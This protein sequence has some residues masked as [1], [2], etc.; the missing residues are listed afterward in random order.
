LAERDSQVEIEKLIL[1][2][3]DLDGSL[4]NALTECELRNPQFGVDW[5]SNLAS[6]A[7]A[8]HEQ[9]V[10]FVARRAPD[11]F[12]ALPMKLDLHNGHAHALGN[13]YTS[14][15][16]PVINS[17]KPESLLLNLF[18]H[19]ANNPKITRLT[20]S[21]MARDTPY[22]DQIRKSI[23]Q[24]GWKGIHSYFCFGNWIHEL[25]GASYQSY[26]ATRP[27]QL[28][29][30]ITRRT[31]QFLAGNR[32]KLELVQGGPLLEESIGQFVAVYNE[33]WKQEEP[34][35]DFIPNLLRLSASRGWLRLG[36]ASY[37]NE[38]VAS[39]I[40]LVSN[41]TAYIFKLAYHEKFKQLS[42]G[43]V[44]TAYMMEH[45]I[46]EDAVSQIDFLSGDDDYKEDWMSVRRERF[47]IAAINPVGLRGKGIL[48]AHL[49][50]ELAKNFRRGTSSAR[51]PSDRF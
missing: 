30:T 11:N 43:T 4:L 12:V 45:V 23:D 9:A 44:L 13:F 33:S 14:A 18:Q 7:L 46:D 48:F 17:E 47:G 50:K 29:N 21:P 32:G 27:S 2:E 19:L 10:L 51:R 31:R 26:L 42:P 24:A 41:N 38:P 3:H 8:E 6:N 37:D 1:L 39:Q 35:T 20:V 36:I 34:Y 22:F 40:W 25:N 15:Y 5:L 49:L 16:S 28:R